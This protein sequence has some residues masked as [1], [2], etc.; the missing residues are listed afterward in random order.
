MEVKMREP[1]YPYQVIKSITL[2]IIFCI[3]RMFIILVL[4]TACTQQKKDTGWNLVWSDEFD[5]SG[6]P[7]TMF[8]DY[9]RVFQHITK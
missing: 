2:Q 8:V 6:L 7:D 3:M 1:Q 4:I 9:V 5:Y